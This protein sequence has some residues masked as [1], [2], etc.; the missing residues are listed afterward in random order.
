MIKFAK[1]INEQTKECEIGTGFDSFRYKKAGMTEMEVEQGYDG[2]WYQLGFTPIES[3]SEKSLKQIIELENSIQPR[4]LRSA[5][6]GD[7]FA[8]NK[9][10]EIE[11]AISILRADI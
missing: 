1:I 11:N 7:E 4:W 3:K 10:K 9:L 6:L 5:M 2:K 8:I